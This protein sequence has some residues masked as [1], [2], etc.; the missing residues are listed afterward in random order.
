MLREQLRR[1]PLEGPASEADRQVRS[2]SEELSWQTHGY[3]GA[4]LRC[5]CQRAALVA[6]QRCESNMG[7][8]QPPEQQESPANAT[9]ISRSDLHQAIQQVCACTGSRFQ[10]C[11]SLHLIPR[12][13][14]RVRDHPYS[15]GSKPEAM[16]QARDLSLWPPLKLSSDMVHSCRFGHL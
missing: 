10:H 13:I 11:E 7:A 14:P 6:L 15:S 16:P 8:V 5:V 4:D 1:M 3:S 12:S 9:V 2:L